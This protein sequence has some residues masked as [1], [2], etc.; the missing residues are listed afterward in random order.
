MKGRKKKP[1]SDMLV[2]GIVGWPCTHRSLPNFLK[3]FR[4]IK[5]FREPPPSASPPPLGSTL[6]SFQGGGKIKVACCVFHPF[7]S[8]LRRHSFSI[9]E[10]VLLYFHPPFKALQYVSIVRVLVCSYLLFFSLTKR[11]SIESE[12]LM[13]PVEIH[14]KCT[15]EYEGWIICQCY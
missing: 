7:C 2:K 6:L 15:M 12:F 1:G 11:T 4:A 10:H 9:Y 8:L 5:R 13:I 3:W 14:R